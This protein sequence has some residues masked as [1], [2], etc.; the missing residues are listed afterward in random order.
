M[1]T[2]SGKAWVFGDDINTDNL[3]P[4]PYLKLPIDEVAPHCLESVDPDFAAN[5]VAGDIVVAGANFG[6]GS[7]REQAAEV[8]RHLGVGA[9][10]A[11]SFGG[12]FYRNAF[13]FGLLALVCAETDRIKAGDEIVLSPKTGEIHN[14]TRD[15]RLSVEAIPGH[16]LDLV[17]DGGLVPHLE[18]KRNAAI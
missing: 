17:R 13:N 4:G 16:L 12:I 10:I 3:A 1:S 9:V 5:I 11:K 18:R 6:Q 15:E 7:S 14:L 2:A 8:L